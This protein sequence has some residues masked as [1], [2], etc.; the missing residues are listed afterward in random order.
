MTTRRKICVAAAVV[1][2]VG[3]IVALLVRD[4]GPPIV[5]YSLHEYKNSQAMPGSTR[6]L[7]LSLKL[8]W[9]CSPSLFPSRSSFSHCSRSVQVCCG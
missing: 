1:A 8:P 4:T 7:G 9:A 3:V 5:G 2:V 6:L